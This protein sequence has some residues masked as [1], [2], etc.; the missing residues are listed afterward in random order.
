MGQ[1]KFCNVNIVY[2]L[3]R[4]SL[5]VSV[6]EKNIEIVRFA[7]RIDTIRL[8]NRFEYIRFQKSDFCLFIKVSVDFLK[9]KSIV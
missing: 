8:S 4:S 1:Q 2:H 5:V 9:Q 3:Y 7:I 6:K